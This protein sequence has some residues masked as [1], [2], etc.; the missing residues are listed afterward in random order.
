MTVTV[1]LTHVIISCDHLRKGILMDKLSSQGLGR[2]GDRGAGM[3]GW[4][5][6]VRKQEKASS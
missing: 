4:K 1:W 2:Q 6:S 5:V 3:L